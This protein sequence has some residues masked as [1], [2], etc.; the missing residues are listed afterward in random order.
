[1]NEERKPVGPKVTVATAAVTI[2][3]FTLGQFGIELTPEVPR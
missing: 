1:M 2:P 3:V